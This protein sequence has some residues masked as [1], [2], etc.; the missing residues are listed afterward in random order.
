MSFQRKI[1]L[2]FACAAA[3]VLVLAVVAGRSA[4]QLAENSRQVSSATERQF[5]V[6]QLQSR[7]LEAESVA[8]AFAFTGLPLYLDEFESALDRVD[9]ALAQLS[10]LDFDRSDQAERVRRLVA[11]TEDRV[12]LFRELIELRTAQGE[13]AARE[14]VASGRGK[15]VMDRIRGLAAEFNATQ[16]AYVAEILERENQSLREVSL[17]L[18]GFAFINVLVLG[19]SFVLMRSEWKRGGGYVERLHATTREM[20]LLG[21]MSSGLQ[22]CASVAEGKELMQHFLERIFPQQSG[23]LYVIRASR[24]ILE[25]KAVWGASMDQAPLME[26][27]DCWGLRLGQLHEFVEGGNALPCRHVSDSGGGYLCVPMMAEGEALG[28]LHL[29]RPS[30]TMRAGEDLASRAERIAEQMGPVIASLT[31]REQFRQ[32][33][34]RDGLTGLYNRRYLEETMG[35]ELL[36]ARRIGSSL[37]VIMADVDHFKKLNDTYGHQAGDDVLQTFAVYLK[38]AVRGDDIAC[39][40]G[41]EE[42]SV[43]L[44]GAGLDMAMQR[45]EALRAGLANLRVR[46]GRE[47]LPPITASFGVAIFPEHGESWEALLRAADGALYAAKR[48][49]RN[50][51]SVVGSEPA[52]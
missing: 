42:F 6:E 44:P 16:S 43:I 39:R 8:R 46:I 41:G 1:L 24:N 51:V 37:A 28:L 50:R 5:V 11:T 48:A 27:Q 10:K 32:Q 30:A 15:L 18:G 20:S 36:R 9:A 7:L 17:L 45:A 3:T 29:R 13:A 25:V 4:Y 49:G 52:N 22:S 26:S 23:A 34:I 31:L 33:S 19:V 14:Q 12:R 40:Y 47:T 21:S 2:A 35:R 38:D